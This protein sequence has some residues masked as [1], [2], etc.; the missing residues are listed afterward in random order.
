MTSYMET[1][2]NGRDNRCG[3]PS[4]RKGPAEFASAYSDRE[5]QECF[6]VESNRSH[7]RTVS[8]KNVEGT[9]GP[10]V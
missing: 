3:G 4:D 5:I 1:S 8:R 7:F 10:C 6:G 2:M 9:P